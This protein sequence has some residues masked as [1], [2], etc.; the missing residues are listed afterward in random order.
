MGE[1]DKKEYT[2]SYNIPHRPVTRRQQDQPEPS[3]YLDPQDLLPPP[4]DGQ[5]PRAPEPPERISNHG[6]MASADLAQRDSVR[7]PIPPPKQRT[8]RPGNRQYRYEE[9][10]ESCIRL[11]TLLPEKKPMIQ[12]EMMHVSLNDLPRYMAISYAWGDAH[13]TKNIEL[14]DAIVPISTSL[15]G[16]LQALRHKSRPVLV[17]ADALCI[18]Q[19][20]YDERT[21]QVALMTTIYAGADEVA[22]WLGPEEDDSSYAISLLHSLHNRAYKETPEE[23]ERLV[24]SE[25]AKPQGGRFGAIVDLFE[26]DYWYACQ[27]SPCKSGNAYIR[28]GME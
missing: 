3:R 22:L 5:K 8:S 7:R 19:K 16:A 24:A 13:D 26:R 21:E 4:R 25:A 11:I 9:L 1:A 12:C 6:K 20:D 28:N 18:N 10:E 17:W 14:E 27:T 15:H 23:F 2:R